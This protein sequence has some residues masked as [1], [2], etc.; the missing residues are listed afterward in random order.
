MDGILPDVFKMFLAYVQVYNALKEPSVS[1]PSL[2]AL[3][4]TSNP[5]FREPGVHTSKNPVM[6]FCGSFAAGSSSDLKYLRT[7]GNCF[8]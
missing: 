2:K 6:K 3:V 5:I 7:C 1:V 4:N 8:Q